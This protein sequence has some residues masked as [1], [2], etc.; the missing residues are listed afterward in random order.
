MLSHFSS[1]GLFA[2]PWTVTC[3]APPSMGFSRQ[4][5]RSGLPCPPPG[6]ILDAGIKP[7]SLTS[8]ASACRFFFGKPPN[9]SM[10]ASSYQDGSQWESHERNKLL[11]WSSQK[12]RPRAWW[13]LGGC[14]FWSVW[15]MCLIIVSQT[16]SCS[17]ETCCMLF[18][19]PFWNAVHG[20]NKDGKAH[21]QPRVNRSW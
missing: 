12:W 2:T 18:L 7:M 3:Q 15:H 16:I 11:G 17:P 6:D 14:Q 1:V 19:P 5:Y 21:A 8:P 9:S 20:T 13:Y 10:S 4:E